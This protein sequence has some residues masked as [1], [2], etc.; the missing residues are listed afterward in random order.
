LVISRLVVVS[1]IVN[2]KNFVAFLNNLFVSI[3]SLSLLFENG[4][5]LGVGLES[6]SLG[7]GNKSSKYE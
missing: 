5:N 3:K 7:G 1:E 2:M 6:Y 4:L